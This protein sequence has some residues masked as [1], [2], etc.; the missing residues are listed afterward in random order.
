[1]VSKCDITSLN[2]SG[3]DGSSQNNFKEIKVINDTIENL[4]I[5]KGYCSNI[6]VNIGATFHQYL[7]KIHA[8]LIEKMEEYLTLKHYSLISLKKIQYGRGYAYF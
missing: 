4:T 3:V 7:Q 5:C 1:M 8:F 2:L 6:Y